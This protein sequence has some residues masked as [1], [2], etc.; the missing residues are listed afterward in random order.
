MMFS[1]QLLG[2]LQEIVE[3]LAPTHNS[4]KAF[5]FFIFYFSLGVSFVVLSLGYGIATTKTQ[6]HCF[7]AA[8]NSRS[9]QLPP[10]AL[11]Q[12]ISSGLRSAFRASE[13]IF[14][15]L[16]EKFLRCLRCSLIRGVFLF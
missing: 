7:I 3:L 4:L 13:I 2:F 8:A 11:P 14:F 1:F 16:L 10:R 5:F 12:L 9:F 6:C 15:F